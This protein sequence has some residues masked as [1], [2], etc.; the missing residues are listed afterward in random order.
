MVKAGAGGRRAA[1][2]TASRGA[3]DR[4][5]APGAFPC[6]V[7]GGRAADPDGDRPAVRS[8]QPA[9]RARFIRMVAAQV[10]GDG[11]P[12][13]CGHAPPGHRTPPRTWLPAL[14]CAAGPRPPSSGWFSPS[15]LCRRMS[16]G[17]WADLGA[18][19][20]HHGRSGFLTELAGL[21]QTRCSHLASGVLHTLAATEWD[22]HRKGAVGAA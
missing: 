12:F 3:G 5:A 1:H 20:D 22:V 17:C 18:A 14:I 15:R 13:T 9:R 2:P 11:Q 8:A 7:L 16:G 4:R 6:G 19:C 21:A 10:F